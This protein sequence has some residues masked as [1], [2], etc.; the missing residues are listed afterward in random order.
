MITYGSN[1]KARIIEVKTSQQKNFVTGFYNKYKNAKQE[2]PDFGILVQ[3]QMDAEHNFSERFFILTHAE[4]SVIQTK[5]N[6]AYRIRC[7]DV[8]ENQ[9]LSWEKHYQLTMEGYSV[10]NVLVTDVEKFENKW[11]TIVKACNR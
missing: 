11:D 4:L 9:R 1:R 3:V 6:R 2:H 8:T 10:D 7:G 5:R